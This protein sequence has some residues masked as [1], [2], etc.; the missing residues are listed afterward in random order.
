MSHRYSRSDKAK[1]VAGSLKVARRSPVHAA[2][3]R[4]RVEINGLSPLEMK[5]PIRLPHGEIIWV[6]FEYEKLEKHCF[7]CL[8]LSHEKKHCPSLKSLDK[9]A[10]RPLGISQQ[11]TL[12]K[13]DAVKQRTW[14]KKEKSNS[15]RDF[16]LKA[17]RTENHLGRP[18]ERQG[19]R[20]PSAFRKESRHSP[21]RHQTAHSASY[22]SPSPPSDYRRSPSD[23]PRE[24]YRYTST[25]RQRT[26]ASKSSRDIRRY[27]DSNSH[28]NYSWD[29]APSKR[30]SV[31][32]YSR[33][34]PAGS[35]KSLE[36]H[37]PSPNPI[38]E[39]ILSSPRPQALIHIPATPTSRRPA[40]ERI[41]TQQTPVPV[42]GNAVSARSRPRDSG[43]R[44]PASLRLGPPAATPPRVPAPKARKVGKKR[45]PR[46]T[47]PPATTGTSKAAAK[48]KANKTPSSRVQAPISPLTGISLRKRN[49]TRVTN[50]TRKRLYV[51]AP[52]STS[53]QSLPQNPNTSGNES[54]G[55]IPAMVL[56]SKAS[57]IKRTGGFSFPT[58]SSSL[59][60]ASWNCQ[61][62]RN[63]FTVRR[64]RDIHHDIFP[65]VMFLMETKN[66]DDYISKTFS[67]MGYTNLFTIPP[68]G[69]SGGLALFSKGDVL[70]DILDSSPNFIDTKI[71][72]RGKVCFVTFIYGPPKLEDRAVFWEF[73][74]ALGSSRE[75]AWILTGDFNEILDNSEKKGG[76]PRHEGSFSNFRSCVSQ[77]GLWDVKHSGNPLSWRGKRHEHHVKCRLD[78]TLSNA[79]WSELFPAGRCSYL[80]FEGSDHRPILTVF[81]PTRQKH[82]GLFRFDRKLIHNPTIREIIEAAWNS[83]P[84]DSVLTK[85]NRCR[86]HIIDW[87]KEQHE[88][89]QPAVT[90]EMNAA[91]TSIPT[92]EEIRFAVFGIN[93][94]KAPGPDGFSAGFYQSYW[95]ILGED[96]SKEIQSFFISGH[97]PNRLNE[98]HVCLIPKGQAP[99]TPAGFRPIAL[100]NVTYK[101]IAKI[102]THHLQP[103]LNKLISKHQSALVPGRAI[104]DNVLIT[105][106]ML[107][108]LRISKARKRC[109]MAVKTDMS[110]AYDRLEWSFL[111]AVLTNLG[112]HE[113]WIGWVMECVSSVSYSFLING[114][115]HGKVSPTRGIRQGDPLS[116]YLF[117]LCTEVLSG[118]CL[119][120]QSNGSLP[121]IKVA[122]GSPSIN[123]L[124]FADDTMFFCRSD[125]KHCK[126]LATIIKSYESASGQSINFEKSSITFSS[127]TPQASKERSKKILNIFKEGGVGKYL[128]LPEHFGRKKKD[129]FTSIVD[130]IQQRAHSWASKFLSGAGKQVLL[131]A[132]LSALP[133]YA[134]SSFKL[135]Q[136]LCKRIQSALTRFWWDNKADQRKICWISWDK[137]TLP[138]G[139]GGLGFREIEEFNDA[140]LAKLSWRL[141][142]DPTSL[143]AQVLLGKYC[144]ND[145]FLSCQP[146]TNSSHGWKG[147]LAGRKLLRKGL[148]W[149]VGNG[150]SINVWQDAW[151]STSS[152]TISFGPPTKQ[153]NN[154]R[155]SDLLHQDSNSWNIPVKVSPKIKS[156]LW[157]AAVGSLPSGEQ[158]LSR[159]IPAVAASC[160]RC[161]N[162][163]STIHIL[164]HC[165]FAQR[166][167]SRAPLAA[168]L[169]GSNILRTKLLLTALKPCKNLPPSGLSLTP[170]Y[171]WILWN[172]W[173]ARNQLLFEDR[174]FSEDETLLK[175]IQ[176]AKNWQS[177]QLD[178]VPLET[179]LSRHAAELYEPTHSDINT[180]CLESD[181][182]WNE[183]AFTCGLGWIG[184]TFSGSPVFKGT[185]FTPHVSST[186]TGEALAVSAALSD[187]LSRGFTKIHL[188]SDSKVLMDLI[189]SNEVVNELVGLLHD[190]RSLASLFTSVSFTFVPRAAN[191]LADSLA[192]ASLASLGLCSTSGVVTSELV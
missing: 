95:D 113:K 188:K 75:S 13:I 4:V 54:S 108:Y 47:K 77:L 88:V 176:E 179:S 154:L 102:L 178:S 84:E 65:D 96:L 114:S 90:D 100:C 71:S 35:H 41:A 144:A 131:K 61:R 30:D 59:V 146:L 167:W 145:S 98:T 68:Q 5:I 57:Y 82:R 101:I 139:A 175:A 29:R 73:L 174:F 105:H 133:T 116:P 80:N 123:H 20:V 6:E 89:I 141:L 172:L 106:E 86:R 28:T 140:L 12:N 31:H 151:L 50:S 138:K 25:A 87:T 162:L 190:I 27:P 16:S 9:R 99:K 2:N 148:G 104:T 92:M 115:P 72:F 103:F 64:L 56:S 137:L 21:R 46:T 63:L 180:I 161:G 132:V 14:E 53:G 157:K 91:L 160:K 79:S 124:L 170:I 3:A 48:K 165:P 23:S 45:A 38:R 17:P 76:P 163:E 40:L 155:V 34:T 66:K 127:K 52:A 83:F 58:R 186:L 70:L 43:T 1:W 153:N 107:R 135:P 19:S 39:P 42:L 18:Y 166:V 33:D 142:K 187:A 185:R 22:R 93:P 171:P 168:S 10:Q 69:L 32:Y 136:S 177:A 7:I 183:N 156:F 118:L 51:D 134:M 67:W 182:A 121:G 189:H 191:T 120:A 143:L 49:V 122:C 169:S 111:R 125:S 81:D 149:I 158:L 184:R 173:I 8:S 24:F 126:T 11:L 94:E 44:I 74:I 36:A 150:E 152:P 109:F 130:R 85:T 37:T 97:L 181:A 55:P 159:G 110:K 78:R 164:L 26:E 119:K 129:I 117:I 112:I 60:V 62:L 15:S 147:I 128:G 192:K